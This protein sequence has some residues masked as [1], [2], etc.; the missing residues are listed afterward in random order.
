MGAKVIDISGG[1]SVY[2]IN[3]AQMKKALQSANENPESAKR[4][5]VY[6][7][8]IESDLSRNER[9]ALAFVIVDNLIKF[10]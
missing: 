7:K 10:Q 3:E 6:L 9:A 5:Q 8:S 4:I 2:C 1:E